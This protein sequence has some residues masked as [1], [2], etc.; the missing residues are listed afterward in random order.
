MSLDFYGIKT[1][2]PR[3]LCE[4]GLGSLRFYTSQDWVETEL[5]TKA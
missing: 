2:V 4:S 5:P 3:F 1:W